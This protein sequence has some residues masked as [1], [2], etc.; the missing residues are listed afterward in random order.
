MTS[1]GLDPSAAKAVWQP[2]LDWLAA[3]PSDYSLPNP[4]IVAAVEARN[5]W[6]AA[7]I[8]QHY[9]FAIVPNRLPHARREEFWWSGDAGQVGQVLYAY[10]S[11][12][13]PKSLLDDRARLARAL[14]DAS[15]K[16]DFALHFNKGLAGAPPEAIAAARETATN[17]A[18][19]DAV[20]LVIAA[21]GEGPAYPGLRGH[22]P[23]LTA[24]KREADDVHACMNVLRDVAP[25]G[26]SYVS[27]SD[28]FDSRWQRSYWGANYSKLA[29]IKKKYDP[30]GLFIVHHGV[31]SEQWSADGFTRL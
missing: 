4:P 22:E 3:N 19:L 24:A 27:E 13:L 9:P 17:P 23:D 7:F 14:F 31:G 18:V 5:W 10:E 29:G 8:E 28:F 15:R 11:L 25:D 1:Y 12:W 26:G 30:D 21:S 20:A 2:F 6:N 16:H